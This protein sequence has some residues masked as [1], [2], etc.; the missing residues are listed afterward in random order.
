MVAEAPPGGVPYEI[1]LK[2]VQALVERGNLCLVGID[3]VKESSLMT[4]AEGQQV[5]EIT[6]R[7]GTLSHFL[8]ADKVGLDILSRIIYRS[9]ISIV[10]AGIAI[11]I[12]GSIGTIL[13]NQRRVLRQV[14]GRADNEGSG[15]I[16]VHPDHS[17]GASIGGGSWR[18]FRDGHHG[19]GPVAWGALRP[20]GN[21]IGQVGGLH[22]PRQSCRVIRLSP[23][24]EAHLPQ[25]IQQPGG[26]DY[27]A[28]RFRNHN[29]VNSEFSWRGNSK[30]KSSQGPYGG[31][32]ARPD[33]H[34]LGLVGVILPWLDNHAGSAVDDPDGRLAKG[35]A[36]PETEA[37]VGVYFVWQA[38]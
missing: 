37:G 32:W 31:R 22:S 16:S 24:A 11:F 9:R 13:G 1:S 20:H 18:Q 5:E 30:T 6:A 26:A 8:G 19:A 17:T 29:R 38:M 15:R 23:N 7:G 21:A 14:A 34:D 28:G 33:S 12:A 36:G 3:S 35:Q 2:N 25:R 4:V 10:V 27:D